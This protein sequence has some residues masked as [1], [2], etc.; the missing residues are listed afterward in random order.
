MPRKQKQK[1]KGLKTNDEDDKK[2]DDNEEV[3]KEDDD[4]DD[5]DDYDDNKYDDYDYDQ[6]PDAWICSSQS[7]A[8]SL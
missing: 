7:L 2:K 4:H 1:I 3:D 6:G 5:H 8:S